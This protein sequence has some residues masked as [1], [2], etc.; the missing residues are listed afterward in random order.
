M[1]GLYS[2]IIPVYNTEKYIE[3]CIRSVIDQTY[4]KW[5]LIIIDDGSTDQS[6]SIIKEFERMDSRIRVY[7]QRNLGVSNARNFGIRKAKGEFIMFLDSDDYYEATLLSEVAKLK[8]DFICFGYQKCFKNRVEK[9]YEEKLNL[10]SLNQTIINVNTNDNISGF[11]WNKVFISEIIKKNNLFFDTNIHYCEDLLFVNEYINYCS[12]FAYLH[13]TLYNYRMRKSSISFN[14]MNK[15]NVTIFRVYSYLIDKYSKNRNIVFY[16]K[17]KYLFN[18][19]K[20][21]RLVEC[22]VANCAEKM[23]DEEKEIFI[24]INLKKK[25]LILYRIV[26]FNNSLYIILKKIKDLILRLYE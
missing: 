10:T 2:I 15:K 8:S 16:L 17:Y 23:L 21:K 5:E 9:I 11:L 25:E 18:F 13:T 22:S 14:C 24:N 6:L 7:S 1:N 3:Q 19:F 26:K 12:S 20:L 4:N